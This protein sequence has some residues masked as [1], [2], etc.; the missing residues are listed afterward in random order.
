MGRENTHPYQLF[1]H[2]CS[3]IFCWGH[4]Y[5]R[6]IDWI[7]IRIF[8]V[9][10]LPEGTLMHI[11]LLLSPEQMPSFMYLIFSKKQRISFLTHREGGFGRNFFSN[12]SI[13]HS[14]SHWA[15]FPGLEWRNW[16]LPHRLSP[17]VED[18][19]LICLAHFN[20]SR[21]YLL[22]F[23]LANKMFFICSQE[24]FFILTNAWNSEITILPILLFYI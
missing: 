3:Y 16:F 14:S 18:Y 2:S 22:V 6:L 23:S 1:S 15:P 10:F 4:L 12:L 21:Q 7:F 11:R 19:F 24:R 17:E 8:V 13:F 9:S 5:R 20:K